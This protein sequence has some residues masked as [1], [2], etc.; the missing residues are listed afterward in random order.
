MTNQRII[1]T[2][3]VLWLVVDTISDKLGQMAAATPYI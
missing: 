2:D 3:L 1:L